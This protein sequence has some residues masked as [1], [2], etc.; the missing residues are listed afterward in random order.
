MF[1]GLRNKLVALAALAASFIRPGDADMNPTP[2]GPTVTHHDDPAFRNIQQ[3]RNRKNRPR[4]GIEIAYAYDQYEPC[5]LA[6]RFAEAPFRSARG[7]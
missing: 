6:K 3:R 7:Y 5:K 4:A 1:N 2:A